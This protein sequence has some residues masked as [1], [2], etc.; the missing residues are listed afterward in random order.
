VKLNEII[1]KKKIN[2]TPEVLI[3]LLN[4]SIV[5]N[6]VLLFL[7]IF[8][9]THPIQPKYF[10][11]SYNGE[12]KA[13]TNIS[14]PN[15]SDYAVM[16]WANIA[17]ISALNYDFVNYESQLKNASQFFTAEGWDMYMRALDSS[18]NLEEVVA[19]KLVV[20]VVATKP[21][22]ILQKGYLN[23]SYSW[24]IQIPVLI[25]YKS[26]NTL[27]PQNLIITMLVSRV[28]TLESYKGLGIKQFLSFTYD[29][30]DTTT[31][32]QSNK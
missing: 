7:V 10:S 30:A 26:A 2:H 28:P 4:I 1:N 17:A 25:T 8:T 14:E 20:N 19:K 6:L 29:I 11:T 13:I 5:A 32:I 23:G 31:F 21:P 27:S 3:K 15:T 22:I 18:N 9:Y 24:R 16:Q 12:I